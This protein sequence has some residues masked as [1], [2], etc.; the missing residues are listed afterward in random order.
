MKKRLLGIILAIA[1]VSGLNVVAFAGGNGGVNEPT[2][3]TIPVECP[4][5]DQGQDDDEQ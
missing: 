4:E 5:D 2:M 1:I 3:I